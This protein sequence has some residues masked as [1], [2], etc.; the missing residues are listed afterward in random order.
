MLPL[1]TPKAGREVEAVTVGRRIVMVR[2]VRHPRSRRYVLRV[3]ADGTVRLTVPR[4]GNRVAAFAF[5]RR[6][7]PWIERQRYTVARHAG[8]ILFRGVV[9]PLETHTD[10]QAERRWVRFGREAVAMRRGET[11]KAAACRRLREVA[12]NELK[13]RLFA[14]AAR[15]DLVVTR[16]TIRSQATRWGS[17]SPDG[18][19]ALNWRL[20]QMPDS[21]RD[22]ILVHELMHLRQRNHSRR[23][24]TMVERACPDY[25]AARCWL[26]AHEGELM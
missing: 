17:C 8:A 26:K 23:F 9:L 16:A 22:Y 5:L 18:A 11:A 25:K 19:V 13:T 2:L 1:G 15:F 4:L 6:E 21:V 10:G 14:L 20:V 3:L 7:L 12:G 24:W